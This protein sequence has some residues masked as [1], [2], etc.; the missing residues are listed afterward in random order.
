M[1]IEFIIIEL[2]GHTSESMHSYVSEETTYFKLVYYV[3][4]YLEAPLQDRQLIYFL[5]KTSNI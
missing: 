3:Q 4:L 1:Q 5:L 2:F